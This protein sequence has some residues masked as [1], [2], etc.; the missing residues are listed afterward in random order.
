MLSGYDPAGRTV[1]HGDGLHPAR[2]HQ[3]STGG[4]PPRCTPETT[5][6]TGRGP[7]P[8]SRI[9][10]LWSVSP[11]WRAEQAGDLGHG[12]VAWPDVAHD[13]ARGPV[14]GLGHDQLEGDLLV[15]EMGGCGV[16]ELVQVQPPAAG[17]GGVLLEQ[18]PGAVIAQASPA[19]VRA[20]VAA[21]DGAP[22]QAARRGDRCGR[23]AS[24][25]PWVMYRTSRFE[26]PGS[27]VPDLP[28]QPLDRH[29]GVLGAALAQVVAVGVNERGPVL[30]G[31]PQPLGLLCAGVA[32]D[33]VQGQVQAAGAFQQVPFR[34]GRGAAASVPGWSR[35]ASRAAAGL[36]RPSTRSAP[37]HPSARPRSG[38][39]TGASGR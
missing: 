18:D 31:A 21:R 19:G 16:P 36:A 26:L 34:A 28:Q 1:V 39:A 38:H 2:K 3:P 22:G 23:S 14:P 27:R 33:R 32:L 11:P 13:G 15:A 25:R 5:S 30:R 17:G 8:A 37:R 12:C 7:G 35:R 4:V 10:A 6:A 29:R 24:A 20:G 9:A